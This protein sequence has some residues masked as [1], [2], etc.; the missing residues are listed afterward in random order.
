MFLN[1]NVIEM[2]MG[3]FSWGIIVYLAYRIYKKQTVNPKWWK[4]LIVFIVGLFSFSIN[5]NMYGS[6]I[7][8]SILP[9][10]V[11]ILYF[12]LKGN[13]ERWQ[14][15]RHYAWLGFMANFIFLA[16]TLLSMSAHSLI[17]PKDQLS[18]YISNIED[19]TIIP[20]HPSAKQV[21]MNKEVLNSELETMEQ[22]RILNDT[23]YNDTYVNTEPNNRNERFPYQLIDTLPQW[24][25]GLQATVYIE[26]D[27][28]GMLITTSK[29]QLYFRSDD[30]FLKEVE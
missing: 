1:F 13:E 19:A 23:W 26:G 27:G 6:M 22:H 28:K 18:T 7:K 21:S 12:F 3:L 10:G 14:K 15:Y 16:S 8:L 4:I 29:N 2:V 11:W 24:G 30:S 25:S 9:L 5:W 17:Y 20:I